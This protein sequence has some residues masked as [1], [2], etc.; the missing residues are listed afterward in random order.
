MTRKA[1]ASQTPQEPSA[2]SVRHTVRKTDV[3]E[4][5]LTHAEDALRARY[6]LPDHAEFDWHIDYTDGDTAE[7]YVSGVTVTA[8]DEDAGG[9][10]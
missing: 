1:Q 2:P 4:F 5:C 8:S 7:P 9:A 3:W 6:N 10:R